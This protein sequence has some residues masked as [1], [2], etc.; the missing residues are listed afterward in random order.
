MLYK[1]K[2]IITFLLILITP[3]LLLGLVRFFF[4]TLE[5]E[6][7]LKS[8]YFKNNKKIIYF[9]DSVLNAD[10][11]TKYNKSSLVN[12]FENTI[13]MESIEISGAAY[14]PYIYH[15]YF[16]TIINYNSKI[17][18]IIM[19][20]NLRAFS[21]S[22]MRVP[23]FQF[24]QECS[25]L[26]IINFNPDYLCIKE[27]TKNLLFKNRIFSKR[28]DFLDEKVNLKG[29]LN[30]TKRKFFDDVESGCRLVSRENKK[31]YRCVSKEALTQMSQYIQYEKDLTHVLYA[32]RYK[33]HYG[34][35]IKDD[36]VSLKNL[37]A[38]VAI[39]NKANIKVLFYITPHNIED[40]LYRSVNRSGE[41]VTKI[42]E[43]NLIKINE[44]LNGN[45]IYK[46]NL[47]GLLKSKNF[48]PKCAC[49]HIDRQGK[50]SISKNIS[51]FIITKIGSI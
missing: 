23:E 11:N 5:T 16:E 20:I 39:A 38:I 21:S 19:P 32:L 28:K 31:T 50:K 40:I 10:H 12:I 48:D 37:K 17:K 6:K 22:W 26:S 4:S 13:K 3:V 7:V 44:V 30:S 47:I 46:L 45:N 27:H 49:E 24:E 43:Q 51:N 36:N 29:F 35:T 2:I 15:K 14:N 8:I 42:M 25:F 9:G 33:Y 34:E 1:K 18:L 41:E